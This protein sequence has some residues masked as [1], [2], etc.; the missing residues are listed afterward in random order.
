MEGYC[1]IIV[2]P[3]SVREGIEKSLIKEIVEKLALK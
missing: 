3:D 2:T 1:S